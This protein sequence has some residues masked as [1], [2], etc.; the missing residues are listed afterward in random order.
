[1]EKNLNKQTQ[2]TKETAE[3]KRCNLTSISTS[4]CILLAQNCT[5]TFDVILHVR[6]KPATLPPR[7]CDIFKI[8]E[9]QLKSGY[10]HSHDFTTNLFKWYRCL[11]QQ[12]E[13]YEYSK[14]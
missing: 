8:S 4:F 9:T 11:S 10:E 13:T 12:K 7:V 2:N 14:K 6:R 5:I 3:S 1:M